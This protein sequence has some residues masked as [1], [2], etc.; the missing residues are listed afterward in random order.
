MKML[1]KTTRFAKGIRMFAALIILVSLCLL[2]A[3][4]NSEG[5]ASISSAMQVSVGAKVR[6][7]SN[8]A[9]LFRSPGTS[10]I[11][12]NTFTSTP[13]TPTTTPTQHPQCGPDANYTI[14]RSTGAAITPGST[15]AGNH[16]DDCMTAV[17]LPFPYSLYDTSFT[18]LQVSSN[19]NLQFASSYPSF[20]NSCLP[21]PS[22]SYAIFPY[23]DDLRTDTDAGVACSSYPT[24]CGVFTALSGTAPNRVF[25]IEWRSV[26]YNNT[27]QQADFE[28]RLYENQTQGQEQG[29][30]DVIYGQ[31]DQSGSSGTV[32][33]QHGGTGDSRYTKYKCNAGGLQ[34]GVQLTF[35]APPP[36]TPTPTVTGTPPTPTNTGTPTSTP[37]I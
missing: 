25:N 9:S 17:D 1:T 26:L 22:L 28:V 8:V 5:N 29:R 6:T 21:A 16:C 24:G 18:T 37:S 7:V 31:V 20:N 2:I 3:D 23:W 35:M 15:D 36:C 11:V 32:G 34:S 13:T 19:G 10:T 30:F 33:V 14:S 12:A 27:A 4:A